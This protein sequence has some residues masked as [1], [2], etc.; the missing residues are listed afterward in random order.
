MFGAVPTLLGVIGAAIFGY[1]G[2]GEGNT[3]SRQA[4]ICQ[5]AYVFLADER[6][7]P[8][9]TESKGRALTVRQLQ[10]LRKCEKFVP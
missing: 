4:M 7:T 1:L 9:L 3:A 5:Q 10:V 8:Y 2:S 6:P